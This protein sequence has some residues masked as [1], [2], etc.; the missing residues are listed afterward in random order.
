MKES[1]HPKNIL[2]G[3]VSKQISEEEL[4]ETNHKWDTIK[5]LPKQL[6]LFTHTGLLYIA[7]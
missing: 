6:R 7:K 3:Q 5:R 1:K 4:Q 2:A